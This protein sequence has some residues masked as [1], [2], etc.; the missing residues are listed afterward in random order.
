M[1]G[2][3]GP[4]STKALRQEQALRVHGT[5]AGLGEEWQGGKVVGYEVAKL[6]GVRTCHL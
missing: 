3:E 5:K 4:V 6:T 2:V 1:R